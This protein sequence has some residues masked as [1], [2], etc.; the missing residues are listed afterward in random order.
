MFPPFI[1]ATGH[2]GSF[3]LLHWRQFFPSSL[4]LVMMLVSLSFTGDGSTLHHC[5]WSCSWS[6]MLTLEMVPPSLNA[7]G[8]VIVSPLFY[9]RWSLSLSFIATARVLGFFLL[10]WR[11]FLPPLLQL[12]VCLVSPN[13]TAYGFFL[14]N[15]VGSF[16]HHDIWF[17]FP[18]LHLVFI[19]SLHLPSP[20]M[21][22]VPP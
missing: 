15:L 21:Q 12:I 2:L 11:W 20:L 19:A 9:W 22:L 8:H 3:S 18:S 17:P 1:T 7:A 16:L 14:H 6:Y 4:L 13:L 10:H 5:S